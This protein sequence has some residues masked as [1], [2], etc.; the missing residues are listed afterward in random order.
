MKKNLVMR[1]AAVVLMCTLVTACF[2]SSTFAKYTSQAEASST[3]TVA[4]WDITV[5]NN[6]I[7]T[8]EKKTVTVNLFDTINEADTV[9]AESNV[10]K[11]ASGANAIV[12][13]GTGGTFDFDIINNSDVDAKYV[14]TVKVG[15]TTIPL[16]F[17]KN[18]TDWVTDPSTLEFKGELAKNTS[19]AVP[20]DAIMWRWAFDDAANSGT[21]DVRDTALGID[22]NATATVTATIDVV[23]VD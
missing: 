11:A 22:G 6:K 1:I 12:A 8:T 21:N 3:V 2:A 18:G 14:V 20:T 17:S 13:P 23:Q 4:K 10:K 5:E 19:T 9:T 15:T 7:T 16:E